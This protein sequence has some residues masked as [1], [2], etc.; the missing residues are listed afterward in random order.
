MERGVSLQRLAHQKLNKKTN[1]QSLFKTRAGAP[2]KASSVPGDG[3]AIHSEARPRKRGTLYT[4]ATMGFALLLSGPCALFAASNAIE[5]APMVAKSTFVAPLETKQEIG[6]TLCLPLSDPKGA[7]EF[8]QRVSTPGDALFHQ[9]ITPQEFAARYGANTTD[10]AALKEWAASVGLKVSQES[11]ARTVLT[12]RG[13]VGQMQT[14]FKT[15]LNKYRG[16]DGAE[17]YSASFSPIV[18]DAIASKVSSVLGLTASRQFAPHL[19]IGKVLGESPNSNAVDA[20]GK[21]NGT[22]GS[23]PGGGY[24]AANLRT[25]YGIPAFGKYQSNTAVALFE[26]GGFSNSDVTKYA[27]EN[28]L[29]LP[30]L[31]PIGVDHSPT[32]VSDPNVEGEAVLD[33]DMV[34]AINPQVSEI[35]VYEDSIDPYPTALLDALTQV[36][37]DNKVQVLSISYGDDEAN[38]GTAAMEAE[39]GV[40]A[41]LTG[42]G[43]TVLASA[44]DNGAYGRGPNGPYNVAD[45]SS[46]PFVTAVGG[47]TLFTDANSNYQGE[48]V[49]N[50]LASNAGATGGGIS[51]YWPIPFYQTVEV[52][53]G[54]ITN[55]GGSSTFRNVPDVAAVADLFTG[56]SV[57]SK[58]NGGWITIGG[59]SVSAP[60]W[61]GYMTL[62]NAGFNYLGLKDVGYFNSILYSVGAPFYGYGYAAND[63]FDIVEGTNGLPPALSFGSP[64]FSAGGGYDNCTG[65]GS[66]WAANFFPQLA[67]AYVSPTSGPNGVNN[68][69]VVVPNAT[70]AV[71][72]WDAVTGATGYIV[73][74]ADLDSRFAYPQGSVYLTKKTTIKL[75]GLT[76]NTGS[77]SLIVWAISPN[78][79]AE[80]AWTFSTPK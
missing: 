65:N 22:H 61:A 40:L 13:T 14:I 56:V 54:Y 57:Y 80:G 59:T 58:I 24:S 62:L 17:F 4:S 31:T 41:Q 43:V 29:Q 19:K 71:A 64:G 15:Q 8:A 79:F 6:V 66:L 47:T 1:M 42:Q 35:L 12:V 37:D 25:A 34:M 36:A 63:L 5:M 49:W 73:Q 75:T 48:Q 2:N 16:P 55:N 9:Y 30:K 70:T 50:E 28:K 67:G 38:Q 20:T 77:Y 11:I 44:G 3:N 26:Q 46:Q 39:N 33:I 60:I 21:S 74:L 78:S 72:T 51:S 69:N 23:G 76:P 53:P 27:T 18:P 68:L 10:Y 45:P 32:T 52:P 7:A